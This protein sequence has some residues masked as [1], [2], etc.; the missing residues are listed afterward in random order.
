M[1]RGRTVYK[2]EIKLFNRVIE[3][4]LNNRKPILDDQQ[5]VCR[6][7]EAINGQ[8]NRT[9]GSL[10]GSGLDIPFLCLSGSYKAK[11]SGLIESMTRDNK[12]QYCRGATFYPGTAIT[13]QGEI[14]TRTRSSING[15]ID[16]SPVAVLSR[17]KGNEFLVDGRRRRRRNRMAP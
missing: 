2:R 3:N 6:P 17:K 7:M 13:A 12:I 4:Q 8:K 1:L 9:L 5:I 15:F 10:T 11:Y 16:F 14:R